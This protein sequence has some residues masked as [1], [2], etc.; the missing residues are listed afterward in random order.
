[1]AKKSKKKTIAST[2][3][4][5]KDTTKDTKPE[6]KKKI[7]GKLFTQKMPKKKK[8]QIKEVVKKEV[9][10]EEITVESKPE[11]DSKSLKKE[12]SI[13]L[14]TKV[15]VRLS[16]EHRRK[17]RGGMLVLIGLFALSFIGWFLFG[18]MFRPQYLAEILP[19][20]STVAIMEVNIDSQSGQIKSFFDLMRNYPVY[21]KDGLVR[22]ITLILPVDF[23]KEVEPW[24]G[25]RAGVALVST[26]KKGELSRVYFIESR[27]HNLTLEFLK[28]HAMSDAKEELT[29]T[30]YNG[31][32]LY[33]YTLSNLF[34]V[35]F[36]NNYLVIAENQNTLKGL[37]D[38][39]TAGG[40][41]LNDEDQ[42]RKVA[43]N[44]PQGSMID[45]YLNLQKLFNVLSSDESF[46][47]QKG[48]NFAA[49]RPYL[50]IFN[51]VGLT[52]FA[53]SGKFVVQ[54]FVALNKDELKDN[55]YI[56]YNDKYR[57]KLLSLAET[58]PIVLAAGHD[59]SKEIN[60]LEEIFLGSTQ[61]NSS[62]FNGILEAQKEIY[63]G[64]EISLAND[65]YPMLG[66][67]YM[68]EVEGSFDAP[69]VSLV[70]ELLNQ[71]QD[72]QRLEKVMS[73]FEK[74]GGFFTPKVQEVVLPDG[75]KGKEIVASPEKIE[76]YE[77]NYEGI[78]ITDLKLGE[79]GLHLYYAVS[80]D[81]A[82]IGTSIDTL[83]NII[84]RSEE[85]IKDSFT[86]TNF[87]NKIVS[88]LTR[89]A[90]ELFA[91][92]LGAF[93]EGFELNKNEMLKPYL[94]PFSNLTASK[95][96]FSDGISTIYALEII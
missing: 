1:M 23:A 7:L 3:P 45:A 75:T 57:G 79:T 11:D 39:I 26:A 19:A 56:T 40:Q 59:L 73:A 66:G 5:V 89:T 15:K 71:T 29:V 41:R 38:Q 6:K 96:Y 78:L 64:K 88:P 93:T 2:R 17:I 67:E 27:D 61:S 63:L 18:K 4:Q 90:D 9:K 50:S 80:G 84:G 58:E 76:R 53:D 22:L 82:I 33:G 24:L 60:R 83:K 28:S 20:D 85:K 68:F 51:A 65:I 13:Q 8:E 69:K 16:P 30:D 25:R 48:Q 35:T 12:P 54:T 47:V 87:Y 49:F 46:M 70:L 55:K 10:K 72:K 44:L 91:V 42:Y 14:V 36:I 34:E 31:Y 21:Q 62:V 43:N 32:K 81:K 86:S 92:K 77:E 94:L 74:S 37:L 95:N 52:C